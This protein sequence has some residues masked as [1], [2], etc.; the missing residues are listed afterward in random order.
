MSEDICRYCL[1]VNNKNSI[2]PCNCTSPVHKSCLIEWLSKRQVNHN[3]NL[4]EFKKKLITCE[5]CKEQFQISYDIENRVSENRTNEIRNNR[6]II[7]WYYYMPYLFLFI[8]LFLLF[9]LTGTFHLHSYNYKSYINN[10]T[11]ITFQ[12]FDAEILLKKKIVSVDLD[13][14]LFTFFKT[15]P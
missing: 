1:E 5:I 2:T 6:I 14:T 9:L 15:N 4:E 11:N 10:S 7:K 8:F 12:E 3:S 13:D